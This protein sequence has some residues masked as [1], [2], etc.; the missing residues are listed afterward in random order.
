MM[1]LYTVSVSE[2]C[3]EGMRVW[4]EQVLDVGE[5]FDLELLRLLLYDLSDKRI[6]NKGLQTLTASYESVSIE[7]MSQ[8]YHLYCVSSRR[9]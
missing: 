8:N 4:E 1:K 7:N 6:R 2:G 3:V 5:T 9:G